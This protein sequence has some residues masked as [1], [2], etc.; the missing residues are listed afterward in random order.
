M[1]CQF[2]T[3][4][5]LQAYICRSFTPPIFYHVQYFK[6]KT[7]R[8][9]VECKSTVV[10]V[11]YNKI[12]T[13]LENFYY[14]TIWGLPRSSAI[15][16]LLLFTRRESKTKH[17]GVDIIYMDFKK[18]FDSVEAYW[19]NRKMVVMAWSLK[20]INTSEDVVKC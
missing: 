3:A 4:K 9:E 10:K 12:I 11:I 5:S 15:Q 18:A 1:N 6:E 17:E 14:P 16:Q 8:K 7:I 13:H 2:I 20:S 19:N